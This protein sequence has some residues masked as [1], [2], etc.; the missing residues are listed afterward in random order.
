M[1]GLLL[2][3]AMVVAAGSAWAENPSDAEKKRF[4]AIALQC[5][6]ENQSVLELISSNSIGAGER[7]RAIYENGVA[8]TVWVS[9]RD[10]NG[11]WFD[12]QRLW[13]GQDSNPE[14]NRI[15]AEL[16]AKSDGLVRDVCLAPEATRK[17]YFDTLQ[18]NR[19]TLGLP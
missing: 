16:A 12:L 17:A 5:P 10:K 2:G 13:P 9:L 3:I 15:A 19:K 4:F 14:I 7:L 11:D 1:R 18:A 8:T 6:A